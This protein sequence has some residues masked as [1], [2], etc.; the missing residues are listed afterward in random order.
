M[1]VLTDLFLGMML[2]LVFWGNIF[3]IFFSRLETTPEA[4]IYI[5]IVLSYLWG[6]SLNLLNN[7]SNAIRN[8]DMITIGWTFPIFVFG[9]TLS[10]IW[11]KPDLLP[12]CTISTTQILAY[13]MI[14]ALCSI[15]GINR[16]RGANIQISQRNA[17]GGTLILAVFAAFRQSIQPHLAASTFVFAFIALLNISWLHQ[18]KT[19]IKTHSKH[20]RFWTASSTTFLAF[21]LV[22]AILMS[23]KSQNVVSLATWIIKNLSELIALL[24]IYASIPIAWMAE[25]FVKRLKQLIKWAP[26]E[27]LEFQP[28]LNRTIERIESEE[29]IVE[30]P[31]LVTGII[32]AATITICLWLIWRFL[33]N[34]NLAKS[35]TTRMTETRES[36]LQKG[37]LRNLA[38]K[39]VNKFAS[40]IKHNMSKFLQTR[41]LTDP[42]NIHELYVYSLKAMSEKSI[43]RRKNETPFE[44]LNGVSQNISCLNILKSFD[45]ITKLFCRCS[46]SESEPHP[47]EW[48][49]ARQAYNSLIQ[50]KKPSPRLEKTSGRIS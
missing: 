40:Y 9:T 27:A 43:A 37:T 42:E 36:L 41:Q 45:Y 16:K 35:H 32:I 47:S 30:I 11:I 23:L 1:T 2:T 14:W 44:Y 48:K 34:K 49:R 19:I 17:L 26:I 50:P 10:V 25:W 6:Y 21:A 28:F 13:M 24:V 31:K 20:D 12:Q 8:I 46:Y 18:Q 3:Q 7:Y 38:Q 5:I 4:H 33:L 15:Q 29:K 22:L 39:F